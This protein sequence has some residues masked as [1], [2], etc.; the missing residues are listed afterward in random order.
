[1][2]NFFLILNNFLYLVYDPCDGKYPFQSTL[3]HCTNCSYCSIEYRSAVRE[4]PYIFEK[5]NILF[6]FKNILDVIP[7]W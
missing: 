4:A 2:Q 1:M 3:G 5:S 7:V 6:I